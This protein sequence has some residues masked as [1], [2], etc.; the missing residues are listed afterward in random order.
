[1]IACAL[2]FLGSFG[3][4]LAA[5]PP[6]LAPYRDAGEMTVGALTL[7]I[8][9][10]TSY[11]LYIMLGRLAQA[12]FPGNPAYRLALLS[13]CASALTLTV[14]FWFCRRRFGLLSGLGAAV[15]LG[16][17]GIFWSVAVVQEMY[18]LW[19]LGAAALVALA[20]VLR[21]RYDERLWLSFC[22]LYG[23]CLANR[24]DLVLWAPGLLW[25]ALGSWDEERA[26]AWA[27]LCFLV[28]PAVLVATDKNT[29]LLILIVGTALWRYR[30]PSRWLWAARSGALVGL[31]LALY[32]YLPLRSSRGPRL[33]WNHPAVAAN[34]LESVL[35]SKYGGTLDLL[36]KSYAKGSMFIDSMRVYAGHLWDSFSLAGLAA[37]AFGCAA[38]ARRD[39]RRWLG[40]AAAYWWTGP[41]FLLM[42]NMPP[43]PHSLAVVDPFYLASDL[44]LVFWAAEGLSLIAAPALAAAAVA[45]LLVVPFIQG[46]WQHSARR[47]HFFSYDYAKNVLMSLPPGATA[48][49]KKDVQLYTLWSYQAAQGWRPDVRVVAQGLSGSP[50]YQADWRRRDPAIF[51]GPL[52]QPEDW[53]SL[54]RLDAPFF[55]TFDAEGPE[56]LPERRPWGVVWALSP[57]AADLAPDFS[58]MAR[59]GDYVYEGQPDFFT[60][61]LV[62]A[63]AVSAYAQGETLFRQGRPREAQ[64]LF[65]RSWAMHWLYGQPPAFLGFIAFQA[66]DYAAAKRYYVIASAISE[67]LVGLAAEYRA[68][69]DVA[70]A[71]QRASAEQFVQLGVV[72]ERLKDLAAAR[73][74]YG[75]SIE[76]FPLA[77][78]HY[79]LAVLA[80]GRD[81]PV[82]ERELEE[83]LRLEPGN[84]DV[85]RYLAAARARAARRPT[86]P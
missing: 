53:R 83:A 43:N 52:R 71:F 14:V 81:W 70:L 45:L 36:S 16:L 5:L 55:A 51:L 44:I 72:C 76:R 57:R 26:P 35:R 63:Y 60:S 75:K 62:D 54:A 69:P 1:M 42:A 74:N 17:N 73:D 65:R 86:A 39:R 79:N 24:L 20:L 4:F 29:L 46:R 64:G 30:G 19:L 50:W 85:R 2:V 6:A 38:G 11:P 34:F 9:H 66:G 80:W 49:V 31:G 18:A 37:A 59:R 7:G 23:I 32:A 27:S 3:L 41:I 40:L 78:A 68:L 21:D 12:A 47:S 33:D 15:L 56:S 22:L 25:L 58:L 48:A 10:P 67:K 13:A 8:N 77:Q 61:D 82:V 28:F 84:A